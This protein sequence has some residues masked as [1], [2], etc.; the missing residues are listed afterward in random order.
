MDEIVDINIENERDLRNV[1]QSDRRRSLPAPAILQTEQWI[2]D[3]QVEGNI[4]YL[5]NPD[6]TKGVN[7]VPTVRT[8][9]KT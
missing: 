7:E 4:N 5:S 9:K 2:Q 1:M 8:R 3:T 6:V